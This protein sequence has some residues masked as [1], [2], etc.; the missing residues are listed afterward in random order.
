MFAGPAKSQSTTGALKTSGQMGST[1]VAGPTGMPSSP[2]EIMPDGSTA[3][4]MVAIKMQARTAKGSRISEVSRRSTKEGLPR[5]RKKTADAMMC[6]LSMAV[7]MQDP[8]LQLVSGFVPLLIF[9]IVS[10]NEPFLFR[11]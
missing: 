8:A 6:L 7:N 1:P 4:S 2:W 10:A 5:P 11:S 3:A 9:C